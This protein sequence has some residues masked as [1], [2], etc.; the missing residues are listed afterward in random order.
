MTFYELRDRSLTSAC[1]LR[2]RPELISDPIQKMKGVNEGQN[3]YSQTV[4][5][6]PWTS[7][8]SVATA[9]RTSEPTVSPQWRPKSKHR[10]KQ[11]ADL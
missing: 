5:T 1:H 9:T 4:G 8:M 10:T 2:I 3:T 6:D 7:Q 11:R